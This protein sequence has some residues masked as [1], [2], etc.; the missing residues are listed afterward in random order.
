MDNLLIEV[1]ILITLGWA[2]TL[3]KSQ[4]KWL[5]QQQA[6]QWWHRQQTLQAHHNA[7][8]IRDG[9]L[10]QTF[11]F[12]RYLES[13]AVHTAS[14]DTSTSVSPDTASMPEQTRWLERFQTFY[15]SLESLSDQ[16]SPPFLVDSLPLALRFA[17]ENWQHEQP[18]SSAQ[19]SSITDIQFS[20]P[21]DW[22]QSP[23]HQNQ[24]ILSVVVSLLP[25][26]IPPGHSA[27][28]LNIALS[29]EDTCSALILQLHNNP[30]KTTP[31]I[32]ELAEIQHLKEIFHSLAAG[33][34]EISQKASSLT[35]RLHWRTL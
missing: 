21:P 29:R 26:L 25:L 6:W 22:P 15:Q 20:F 23:P 9:L 12:R 7:E 31:N 32:S 10:Q 24:I 33:R 14:S 16:L 8:S 34:L 17:I 19:R 3:Y 27:S 18:H 13:A 28:Q 2:A 11:A 5:R 30:D 1:M 4:R 35:S